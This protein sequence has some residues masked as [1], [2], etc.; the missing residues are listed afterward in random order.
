MNVKK[1]RGKKEGFKVWKLNL[2][3]ATHDIFAGKV[4]EAMLSFWRCC[5]TWCNDELPETYIEEIVTE[6]Q[7]IDSD[8]NVQT[9]VTTVEQV[10]TKKKKKINQK[11]TW[12]Y[13][14]YYDV[15]FRYDLWFMLDYELW[16]V[17][18]II[19]NDLF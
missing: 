7:F 3:E 13:F 18:L 5:H 2:F 15:N 4:R 16:V 10:K 14:D 1:I 6:R 11:V 8:G 17:K 19:Q 12:S 9:E